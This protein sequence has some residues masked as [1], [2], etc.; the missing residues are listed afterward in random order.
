MLARIVEF[1]IRQRTTILLATVVLIA[2]GAWA[3]V[4]LPMDAM[5]DITNIQV[6]VNTA[7][8]TLA[9]EEIEQQVT[10]PLE[11]RLGG[12]PGVI[13][14][15]SLSK[16]GLS[17]VTLVFQDGTDIYRVRQ[18]VSERLQ[19]A[20][21]DLPSG[22]TPRLSPI[23][24]GLGEIFYYT[25]EYA[26]ASPN[27][28]ASRREQL[29]ELRALHE[30]HVKPVLRRTPGI[31]EINTT[32]GY[33]KQ[34]VIQPDPRRLL[35]AGITLS[36]FSDRIA[37]NMRN[38]GGGRVEIGSEQVAIRA[39]GRAATI[40]DIAALPLKFA[41]AVEPILVRDVADVT[42]DAASRT[43]G[44][45][46]DGSE[47]M[48]CA[49]LMLAGE[50]SRLVSH[51]VAARLAEIQPQLPAGIVVRPL[52][53]RSHLVDRTLRTV[54][55]NLGEGALLVIIVLFLFLGNVRAAL[56]VALVIPLAMLCAALGMTRLG[57]PGNLMSLGAIDFGLIVDGAIV[58]V[59]NIVRHVGDRQRVLGRAL[60]PQERRAEVLVSAREVARPM[61]F[62]VLIITLVY[63]PI[64]ALQGIEGK[65]FEPMA[66]VV[67]LA[68]GGALVLALTLMPALCSLLLRG[69][70]R[71]ADSWLVRL[72][73]RVYSPL[74]D[75]GFRHRW[76]VVLPLVALFAGSLWLFGRLGGELL[77]ELDEGDL[78]AFMVRS[79]SAGLEASVELQC[80]AERV[81][82][83]LFPEITHVFSRIGTDEIASDPMDVNVSDAYI[84]LKPREAWR[85][86][87]G[88][89]IDREALAA[90]MA[91]ELT[92][93][94]PGQTYLFSQ[95]IQ[96]RFNEILE[97]TRADVAIK[98]FGPDYTVLER[99]AGEVRTI[100]EG[101]RGSGDVEPDAIGQTPALEIVP[102]RDALRRYNLHTDDINAAVET[103]FA[104]TEVG[105]FVE[106]NRRVPVVV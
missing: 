18:L 90:L 32:G 38:A 24:T 42:I 75:F 98:I 68:L 66:V 49:A 27:R 106:G 9:P 102:K 21:E 104:G 78:T 44:A 54:G 11:N 61:F 48:V 26:S 100:L 19:A 87:E 59:E 63:A 50:N 35:E 10:F 80:S 83:E 82:R 2:F 20:A 76:L 103:A 41:A 6:Q 93:R 89:P 96:M 36:E 22:L 91:A 57:I 97:G 46:V 99:L 62:G 85:R 34:V 40:E 81:L 39:L 1:S 56:I 43:G 94:I 15:R 13:E 12:L 4:R 101:V 95:P 53:N 28:P 17:Q 14:F 8:P 72:A 79:T 64:L 5:P 3:A 37:E 86:V 88:R 33:E 47:A 77:P 29:M 92:R 30:L 55:L 67:M 70:I 74:L 51:A 16:N 65:M 105:R 31:A 7:V 52:Y 60:T 71:E 45:T 73:K 58:M 69:R 25:I 84:M 23:A